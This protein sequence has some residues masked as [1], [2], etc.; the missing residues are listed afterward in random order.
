MKIL[1]LIISSSQ[2]PYA[3]IQKNGQEKTW[4][5]SI[6]QCSNVSYK[7]L[8]SDGKVR[9]R[10]DKL[11][12]LHGHIATT[13]HEPS[14]YTDIASIR[15]NALVMHS[16][17][18]WESILQNTLA[19]FRWASQNGQNFD[20]VIRTNVSSYW[21]LENTLSLLND[22]PKQ[23]LYAGHA[24][25]QLGTN[26]IAGD[27]I[28]LSIDLVKLISENIV[29]INSNVID[30]VAIGRFL[31]KQNIKYL[32]I[33]RPVIRSLFDSHHVEMLDQNFHQFRC[34]VER[35]IFGLK[36]RLDS[37]L[38]KSIHTELGNK[39]RKSTKLRK[40]ETN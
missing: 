16:S 30:D 40:N 21:D 38:M 29:E 37:I 13:E 7:Y 15:K 4:I 20:Y 25:T 22:L 1:F 17:F 24:L 33:P 39:R 31:E 10:N 19:G 2:Q 18:G 36:F 11:A 23:K 34:K 35:R 9:V 28:I 5:K 8:I 14:L 6:S 12:D 26:F 27:G 32:H 3:R